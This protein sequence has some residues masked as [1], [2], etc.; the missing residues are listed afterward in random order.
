MHRKTKV[1]QF[2]EIIDVSDKFQKNNNDNNNVDDNVRRPD[3]SIV[4][5]WCIMYYTSK[6]KKTSTYNTTLIS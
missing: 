5:C 3:G 4:F 6:T 2:S 1:T